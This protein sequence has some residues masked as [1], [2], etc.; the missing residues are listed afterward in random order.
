MNHSTARKHRTTR[1]WRRVVILALALTTSAGVLSACVG[2]DWA[3]YTP[4]N[5]EYER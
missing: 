3:P 2:T 4:V 1:F 5:E